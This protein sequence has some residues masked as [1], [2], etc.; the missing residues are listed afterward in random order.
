[1]TATTT[2]YRS[3][4]TGGRD[5]F[6]QT[7]RAEWTKF[8]TVRSWTIAAV[9]AALLIVLFG[10]LTASGSHTNGLPPVPI[11]P[12]G[13]A[14][15]D[16]FY[17]AAQTL[18][19]DGTITARITSL[20]S[21]D[22]NNRAAAGAPPAPTGTPAPWA[23]A[24]LIIKQNTSAGSAYAAVMVTGGHGVRLQDDYTGDRAGPSGAVTAD[25]PRWLR[26]TRRGGAVTAYASA[27][28]T[29]WTT[30]G[31]VHP[32][33]LSGT[34]RIGMFVAS[35]LARTA[36]EH[37]GGGTDT[38][39]G[40][41]A[42]AGFDNV[43][44]TGSAATGTWTGTSVGA[45]PRD[46]NSGALQ[47][48]GAGYTVTGTGD[49]APGN[50]AAGPFDQVFAGG[51]F[52]ALA[53]LTVLGVLVMTSEYRRGL[54][55]TSLTVSPRRG[56][57]LAARALV[58]AAIAFVAGLIGAVVIVPIGIH[59]LRANGNAIAP[60]SPPTMARVIVGLAAVLAVGAVLGLAVGT[61][62]RRGAAAVA[63]VIV[64]AVLPYLL[65]TTGALPV[66]AAQWLLR[67][68]P[69]AAFAV[70]QSIPAYPQVDRAYDPTHGYF[71]LAPWAGFAVLCA[72]TAVALGAAAYLLRKRDV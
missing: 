41:V 24:G 19:G 64:V 6:A 39:T 48:V 37:L 52:A 28:G 1:M 56:R 70:E 32:S 36:A 30:V 3:T 68:T 60:V 42:T 27:D 49:I 72:W 57:V 18:P 43:H 67:V 65:A 22:G 45:D 9:A 38:G 58:L 26:L 12:G 23:K 4:I 47:P 17:L 10:V 14:V 66:G 29:T 71:P 50:D 46:T 61:I 25:S 54:I 5:G 69:A 16:Q 20:T 40:T 7:L 21:S 62:L 31:T 35:P 33:K 63:P 2:P 15:T 34:V 51:V 59:I 8:R 13:G 11:G 44:L 53:V 55:R